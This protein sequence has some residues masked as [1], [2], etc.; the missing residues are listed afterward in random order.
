MLYPPGEGTGTML[1]KDKLYQ[2]LCCNCN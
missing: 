2:V 1:Y